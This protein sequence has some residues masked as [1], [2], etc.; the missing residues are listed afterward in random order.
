MTT[1]AIDF[2][3]PVLAMGIAIFSQYT[4]LDLWLAQWVYDAQHHSWPYK[5]LW[6][7]ETV[8]HSG[9][10]K[11]IGLLMIGT[12]VVFVLSFVIRRW[13]HVRLATG[14]ILASGLTSLVIVNQLKGITHIYSP[15]DLQVFGGQWPHIRLFDSVPDNA[16][17]GL[18]FP[19]GHAAGGYILLGLYF[20][21][22]NNLLQ[23]RFGMLTIGIV[24]GMAF[25]IAQQFRGAHMLSHDLTTIAICWSVCLAWE[26]LLL[27]RHA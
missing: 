8:L 14:Y 9:G 2:L 4:G 23:Y 5:D 21:A 3:V 1:R 18:G 10:K 25:G 6:I 26:R 17:V 13:R 11:L 20:L 22:R 12:L 16:P 15:W 24:T 27:R 7:T 19:A